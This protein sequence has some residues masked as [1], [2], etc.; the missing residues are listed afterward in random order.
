MNKVRRKSR[1][2]HRTGRLMVSNGVKV[3][4][5]RRAVARNIYDTIV[6][7][8][9]E[10]SNGI[11]DVM[12]ILKRRISNV[13]STPASGALKIPATAP[14]APHPSNMVMFL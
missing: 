6:A 4:L 9:V 3:Q 5:E 12:D 2:E 10:S 13:K 11:I 14:A 1:A 7:E 8:T